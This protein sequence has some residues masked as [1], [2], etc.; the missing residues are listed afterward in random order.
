MDKLI[1]EGP[2]NLSGSVKISKAKNAYLPILCGVLLSDKPVHLRELPNLSDIRTIKKILSNLGVII[3]EGDNVTTFDASGVN[4]QEVTYDIVK[5]MR[6][7]I[8]VMGALLSRFGKAVVSLPGG[9]AIG[10]RPIDIH[11][12]NFEKMGAVI[13]VKG[14]YVYAEVKELRGARLPLRFPS[15]GATENLMM[16]AVFA[17]GKTVIENAARE[18]EV[19]DLANFLKAMGANITGEGSSKI[20][21]EGVDQ[22]KEVDYTAIGDRIEASTYMMAALATNSEITV[23]GFDPKHLDF[24]LTILGE[25]GAKYE[26]L[27]NGIHILK[28][29]LREAQVETAPYPRFPTD[30]QA[31]MM[32]LMTQVEGQSILTENVFENRFMHVPELQ[33][34]GADISLQGK[35]AIIKGGRKL[36]G[37]PVMCTDLRASAS[38]IIGALAAHGTSE[39][40]RVYHLDRGY[41]KLEEKLSG[42]GVSIR[43]HSSN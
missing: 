10:T 35:S 8:T 21:I 4:S 37:A 6:A 22:L 36:M 24:V 26:L 3:E 7:S 43:R 23:E 1:V 18:P 34:L 20:E 13:D 5:T 16:A 31:Q 2:A 27:P 32:A 39:I 19:V 9:C 40:L 14:G 25:M 30:I 38:L 28:S 17:K 41:E 29:K 15:V 33:R 12:A 11:L 42:L